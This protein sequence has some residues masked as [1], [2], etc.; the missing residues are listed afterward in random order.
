MSY[1]SIAFV[2]CAAVTTAS[3]APSFDLPAGYTER[4]GAADRNIAQVSAEPL[5]VSDDEQVFMSADSTVALTRKVWLTRMDQPLSHKLL[6]DFDREMM[7]TIDDPSAKHISDDQRWVGEQLLAETVDEFRGARIHQRRLYAA[8]T[9]GVVHVFAVNCMGPAE[10]LA[11]CEHAQQTMKLVLPNQATLPNQITPLAKP[12]P[13]RSL[14][15]IIGGAATGALV[16]GLVVWV[17]Q[18]ARRGGRRRRQ[19]RR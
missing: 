14:A 7:G 9:S 10:R 4:P 6:L 12:K 18:S 5:T 16:I 11:E 1:R 8:D 15:Q 17:V 2:I 19:R 3:A 13:K